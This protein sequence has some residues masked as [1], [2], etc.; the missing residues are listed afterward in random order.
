MID[1]LYFDLVL[2]QSQH[3]WIFYVKNWCYKINGQPG[4]AQPSTRQPDPTPAVSPADRHLLTTDWLLLTAHQPVMP[5]SITHRS[6]CETGPQTPEHAPQFCSLNKEARTQ[7]ALAPKK[8]HLQKSSGASKRCGTDL[9]LHQY[10]QAR[11]LRAIRE[12]WRKR[13]SCKW[14]HCNHAG[15]GPTFWQKRLISIDGGHDVR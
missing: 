13:G 15:V 1:Q 8:P 10:H 7:L 6:T 12:C 4:T 11:C 2:F 9:Q 14:T 5:R 3:S